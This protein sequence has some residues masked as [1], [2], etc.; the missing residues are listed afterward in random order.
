LSPL[1]TGEERDFV[2]PLLVRLAFQME[3]RLE[4][5]QF[6][7]FPGHSHTSR[8]PAYLGIAALTLHKEFDI[9]TCERWLDYALTI[10]RGVLPFYGGEDGSWVEGPFYS[11]SYTKWH[12]PFF[13]A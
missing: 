12:H 4:Q 3:E 13:L 10:Y 11:S 5:D 2:R 7:Q 8:L 6:K 1:L 9:T